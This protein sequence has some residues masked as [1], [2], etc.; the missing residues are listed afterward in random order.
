MFSLSFERVAGGI[1][2]IV[3]IVLSLIKSLS[4]NWQAVNLQHA[5]CSHRNVILS[6][7]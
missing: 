4:T 6:G 1:F 3:Y 5:C 7:K 2:Q